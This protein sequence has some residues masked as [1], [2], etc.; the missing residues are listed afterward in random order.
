MKF[1]LLVGALLA[2]PAL[3]KAAAPEALAQPPVGKKVAVFFNRKTT[4]TQLATIKQQVLQDGLV[5]EYD[6]LEFDQAGYLLKISFHVES[7]GRTLGS[8]T[9]DSLPTDFS[10]GFVRDFTAAGEQFRIGNFQ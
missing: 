9:A 5:L 6:R 2:A 4:F 8:A 1:L 7:G 10:F 3:A